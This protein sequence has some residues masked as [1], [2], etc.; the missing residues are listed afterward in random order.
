VII[1]GRWY[2]NPGQVL[3]EGW[4]EHLFMPTGHYDRCWT[5][6]DVV[7]QAGDLNGNGRLDIVLSPAEGSGRLSWFE[8]PDQPAAP[9]WREHAIEP[10]LDHAHGLGIADMDGDG[11]PDIAVAK[12]HQATP[13]QEVSIYYNRDHGRSWVKQAIASSGSHNIVL[14]DIGGNGRIDVYGANWN[15]RASTHGMIELW[16][17]Q[18]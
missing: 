16:L 3:E 18:G 2:E 8:A 9:D 6:G 11:C 15:D 10:H 5:N 14:V 13:P 17:N 1:G 7:V 12:M 4:I